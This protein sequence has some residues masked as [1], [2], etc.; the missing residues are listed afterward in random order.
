MLTPPQ[1]E[2]QIDSIDI[3]YSKRQNISYTTGLMVQVL[4]AAVLAVLYPLENPFYTIG[5]MLFELGVLLSAVSLPVQNKWIKRSI[6]FSVAAG[7]ALQTAG[8][9]GAPEYAG[10]IM[11][12]GIGLICIGAG[13]I[14][15]K[16]AYCFGHREG[17]I[18]MAAGYPLIVLR[19]LLGKENHIFNSLGFSAVFLLLLSLIGKKLRQK[20]HPSRSANE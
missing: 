15:G 9:F 19:N 10:S 7:L 1:F 11:L 20:P 17:W 3:V 14:S 4:G 18:L 12:M 6:V 16:E 2:E 5:L 13:G 8:Y